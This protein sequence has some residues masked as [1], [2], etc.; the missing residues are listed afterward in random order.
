MG[1][2]RPGQR[3]Y[4]RARAPHLPW[5]RGALGKDHGLSAGRAGRGLWCEEQWGEGGQEEA[6]LR[7]RSGRRTR[8]FRV[9]AARES[10]GCWGSRGPCT[11][12]TSASPT[13]FLLFLCPQHSAA[14]LTSPDLSTYPC[15]TYVPQSS[16]STP[17]HCPSQPAHRRALCSTA[18]PAFP[19]PQALSPHLPL[20]RGP[21][22]PMEWVG[23]CSL[24]QGAGV[25]VGSLQGSPEPQCTALPSP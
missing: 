21:D 3:G 5:G 22:H 1:R 24:P 23:C 4:S 2:A 7:T 17:T 9:G 6:T 8:H 11:Y 18:S 19:P 12:F 14:C 10:W 13:R 20:D 15:S 16:P 25:R